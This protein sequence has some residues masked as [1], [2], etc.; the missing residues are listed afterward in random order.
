[1]AELQKFLFTTD[2]LVWLPKIWIWVTFAATVILYA[3]AYFRPGTLSDRALRRWFVG[4][5][6]GMVVLRVG[7]AALST[8]GQYYVWEQSPFT[9][10]LLKIGLD[11]NELGPILGPLYGLFDDSRGYFK[12]YVIGRFWINALLATALPFVLVGIVKLY[13]KLRGIAFENYDLKI[14]AITGLLVGWPKFVIFVPMM[15][16]IGLVLGIGRKVIKGDSYFMLAEAM[17]LAAA[18]LLIGTWN[19]VELLGLTVLRI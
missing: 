1:M 16:V 4:L 5:I 8:W 12:Y 17:I 15:L 19:L 2:F 14:M 3:V 13:L 7:Y 10:L 18:I 11:R 9:R 6:I